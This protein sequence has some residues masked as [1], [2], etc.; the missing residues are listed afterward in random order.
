M[1]SISYHCSRCGARTDKKSTNHECVDPEEVVRE[2][3]ALGQISQDYVL[4]EHMKL[5]PQKEK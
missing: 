3:K 2:L 4:P 5:P 1:K